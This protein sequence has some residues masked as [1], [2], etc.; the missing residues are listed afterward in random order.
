[1]LFF[2]TIFSKNSDN[3][4]NIEESGRIII[5]NNNKIKG[6]DFIYDE[7]NRVVRSNFGL[8]QASV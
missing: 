3:I 2:S 8:T 6:K 4:T 7:W 5:K 1:V